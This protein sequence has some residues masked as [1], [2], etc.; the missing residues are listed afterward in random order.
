MT[1]KNVNIA[2]ALLLVGVGFYFFELNKPSVINAPTVFNP[3]NATYIVDGKPVTLVDG[4]FDESA[5]PG[6]SMRILTMIFGEPTVGDLN[7]DG[8]PDA[9]FLLVRTTGG[10]GTF[11][12]VAAAL[13]TA[14]GT[15]GTNALLLGDRIAPQTLEVRNGQIIANY[16]VRYPEEPM[17]IRPSL[18]VSAY[19]N[20]VNGALVEGKPISGVGERCGGNM[21][22]APVCI[23]GSHCA[24]DP[25]SR[26]P[27]GDV[28]GLCVK[29]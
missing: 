17:T 18:G 23:A 16:A 21:T 8:K 20:V 1:W 9:A 25:A 26:L 3:S 28:G 15:K 7:N 24:P 14:E 2:V 11:F 5:A 13:N 12:Y 27:F 29:N 10:S 22:T 19:L 6:S 4:K